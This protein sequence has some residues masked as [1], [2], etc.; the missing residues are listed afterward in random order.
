MRLTEL[1]VESYDASKARIEHP[2]DLV[3]VAGSNGAARA[4]SILDQ[5]TTEHKTVS[6]KPDGKPAIVWGRDAGG[7]AM[8]DKYMFS[9]AE[10]PRTPKQLQDIILARKGENRGQYA[11]FMVNLWPIF[12]NSVPPKFKGFVMGDLMYSSPIPESDGVYKFTPNTVTYT[13][14]A[15]SQTGQD[16][17]KSKAG[18]VAH[19]YFPEQGAVG[20]HIDT[21]VGLVS[22]DLAIMSDA[23]GS[24]TKIKAPKELAKIQPLINKEGAAIDQLLDPMELSKKKISDFSSILKKYVNERVRQRDWNNLA[25]GFLPWTETAGLT[26]NKRT[27]IAAYVKENYKGFNAMFAIFQLIASAKNNIVAQLDKTANEL[28]AEIG[29]EP[30]QEGYVVHTKEG[31]VKLV[32]RF[33]FSAANFTHADS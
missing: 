33:R 25:V 10:L 5:A 29:E 28:S 14:H 15:S 26:S 30:G 6:I 16:I 19:S 31:P 2:E 12:K 23:I 11:Q 8:G 27:N 1:L 3:L 18:V 9:K 4:L 7:F 24:S 17:A 22:G 13:V 21:P 20:K 32:D